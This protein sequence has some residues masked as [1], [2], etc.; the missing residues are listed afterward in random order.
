MVFSTAKGSIGLYGGD[1]SWWDGDE[2]LSLA[3]FDTVDEE[4][5]KNYLAFQRDRIKQLA[6]DY[7]RP[8]IMFYTRNEQNDILRNRKE[9][10]AFF[11]WERIIKQLELYDGK[12]PNNSIASL[13]MFIQKEMDEINEYNYFNK[14][15]HQELKQRSGDF[16]IHRRN[17]LM[18]LLY[19]QCYHLATTTL[20]TE[21][22]F[23]R[24]FFNARLAG[25]F[26]FSSLSEGGH[27]SGSRSQGYPGVLPDIRSEC[28]CGPCGAQR[29]GQSS[30]RRPVRR[31]CF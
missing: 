7:A 23:I 26:P 21:Y 12:K 19:A 25:R 17:E 24:D 22:G 16:F 5:L 15:R 18:E 31:G 9:I 1:F 3:A 29:T 28:P 6:F 11:K 10:Q 14:I 30:L 20:R 4:D 8:L 13:E 2:R 27:V